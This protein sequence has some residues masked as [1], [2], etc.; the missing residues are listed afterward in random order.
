MMLQLIAVVSGKVQHVGYR[1]RVVTMART[2]DL[3]GYVRNLADGRVQ[4]VAEGEEADLER[5]CRAIRLC[6]PLITVD[7]MQVQLSSA[8]GT[9]DDFYKVSGEGETDSRLDTAVVFLKELIVIVK[10]GFMGIDRRL[11]KVE[12]K[13]DDVNGKLEGLSEGGR[14]VLPKK[15][16]NSAHQKTGIKI[17]LD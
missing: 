14:K 2:L 4:V 13:L 6:D 9:W 3:K 12:A 7:D 11:A 17:K 16:E 8:K 5:F 15:D 1:S 10:E